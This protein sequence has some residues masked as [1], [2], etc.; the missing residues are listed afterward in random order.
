MRFDFDQDRLLFRD[1]VGALLADECT[2]D[3]LRALAESETGRSPGLWAKLAEIGLLGVCVPEADGGLGLDEIDLVL[4]LEETGRAGLAEP[5]VETAAVAAPLLAAVSSDPRAAQVLRA[6]AEGKAIVAVAH[7]ENALAADVH[8]ADFVIAARGDEIHLLEAADV[9]ATR[10]E[11]VDPLRR[12]FTI[13][14]DATGA[15]VI[16]RGERVR[17]ALDAAFDRG[18]LA[19]AAQQLGVARR[20]LETAVAYA[21]TREQFGQAIGAF[22]AIKHKLADVAVALEFARPVVHRAAFA[23][24]RTGAG[25]ARGAKAA[26]VGGATADSPERAIT[27]RAVAVSHAKAAASEAARRAAKAALQVHGAIGYTWEVDLHLWMK[28]AWSLDLAWGSAAR[29]RERT[30]EAILDGDAPAPSFGF[31]ARPT[32]RTT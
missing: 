7:P 6:I 4:P 24:A 12:L 9:E 10:E 14:W 3:V 13:E 23:V 25:T 31:E 15:T 27:A 2:P 16:A 29:H 5:V 22:Q 32:A 11:S 1:S 8:V 17:S 28:R 21:C 26:R 18:A 19:T 30:A 20:L